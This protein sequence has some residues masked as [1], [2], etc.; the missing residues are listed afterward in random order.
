MSKL[1]ATKLTSLGFQKIKADNKEYYVFAV[2]KYPLLTSAEVTDSEDIEVLCYGSYIRLKPKEVIS[3]V[4]LF[5]RAKNR[6][7]RGSLQV[8]EE[9][10]V[11]TI[12]KSDT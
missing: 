6:Q 3:Y 4:N 8:T 5:N 7:K 12:S 9:N 2:N 11:V 1:T 10:G